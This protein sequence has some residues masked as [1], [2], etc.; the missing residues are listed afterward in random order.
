[1]DAFLRFLYA[2]S[3]GWAVVF[4]I[5]AGLVAVTVIATIAFA[6]LSR[7]GKNGGDRL[8]ITLTVLSWY[9]LIFATVMG[10]N[11]GHVIFSEA[12]TWKSDAS[13]HLTLTLTAATWW[14]QLL[15]LY[16]LLADEDESDN[17]SQPNQ[18]PSAT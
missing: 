4:D 9:L 8:P 1:M 16:L 12:A 3:P 2:L 15:A 7:I 10:A 17:L 11:W 6:L 14:G 5:V 18:H 13:L